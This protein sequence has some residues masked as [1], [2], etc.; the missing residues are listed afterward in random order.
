MNNI[1]KYHKI[2]FEC[3]IDNVSALNFSGDFFRDLAGV[4]GISEDKIVL[5]F[6]GGIKEFV[7]ELEKFYDSL[8]QTPKNHTRIRDR[9]KNLILQ[10]ICIND[11]IY[12]DLLLKLE[13][14]YTTPSNCDLFLKTTWN[15]ANSMWCVIGDESTD[16]NYYTKRTILSAVYKS[17]LCYYLRD[18]SENSQDTLEFL[19]KAIDKVMLIGKIKNNSNFFS[20]IKEK[21]PFVRLMKRW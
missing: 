1:Q 8:L 17:T 20:H 4:S 15:T 21:I 13:D 18:H 12:K 10:R 14:F 7:S 9:I 5:L 3:V 11:L 6:P 2:L 19:D 16:F